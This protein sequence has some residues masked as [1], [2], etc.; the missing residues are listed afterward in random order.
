MQRAAQRPVP[1]DARGAAGADA[2]GALEI[3]VPAEDCGTVSLQAPQRG[4]QLVVE[5]LELLAAACAEALSVRDVEQ[6][7]AGAVERT[8]L[9]RVGSEDLQRDAGGARVGAG[10]FHR[11]GVAIGAE[12]GRRRRRALRQLLAQPLQGAAIFGGG[13]RPARAG[14]LGLAVFRTAPTAS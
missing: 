11:V 2:E 6:E 9:A 8:D 5:G 7:L 10:G 13:A 12:D 1:E 4:A 3:F 14:H